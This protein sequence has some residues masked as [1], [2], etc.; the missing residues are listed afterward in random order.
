MGDGHGETRGERARFAQC[1]LI[2]RKHVV[3]LCILRSALPYAVAEIF[4][5]LW[6]NEMK[7]HD[8][9]G[10]LRQCNINRL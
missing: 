4:V 5:F 2:L 7:T 10:I 9:I 1:R 6:K 3:L 8:G